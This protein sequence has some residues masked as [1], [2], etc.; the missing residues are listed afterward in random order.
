[1]IEG[2]GIGVEYWGW[3][4]WK[5]KGIVEG[6]GKR[7]GKEKEKSNCWGDGPNRR[8]QEGGLRGGGKE[9]ERGKGKRKGAKRRDHWGG[10]YGARCPPSCPL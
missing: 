1:M 3:G 7:N 9:R 4:K 10:G 6:E 8:Q 2:G 5:E